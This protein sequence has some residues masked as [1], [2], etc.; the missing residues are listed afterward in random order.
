M[1][2]RQGCVC[3]ENALKNEDCEAMLIVDANNALKSIRGLCSS[4]ANAFINTYCG[5]QSFLLV[6]LLYTLGDTLAMHHPC[7][8]LVRKVTLTC[9]LFKYSKWIMPLLQRESR[10]CMP[11]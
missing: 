11:D 5:E 10:I 4:M 7:A 2:A 9:L 8:L 3:H 6:D 1:K